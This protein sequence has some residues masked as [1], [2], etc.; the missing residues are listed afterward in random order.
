MFS[1]L[2]IEL[3]I[4]TETSNSSW[5][6]DDRFNLLMGV[7]GGLERLICCQYFWIYCLRPGRLFFC[8]VRVWLDW[9]SWT[10]YRWLLCINSKLRN[11]KNFSLTQSYAPMLLHNLINI[12]EYA[13]D[14]LINVGVFFTL[15]Q[16]IMYFPQLFPFK[17]LIFLHLRLRQSYIK[18]L[19]Y[20][21]QN[22]DRHVSI[23]ETLYSLYQAL[24]AVQILLN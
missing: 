23:C 21:I 7:F 24:F 8:C 1:V 16:L 14:D 13:F 4:F 19:S 5:S 20:H 2:R 10:R 17:F 15:Y 6:P 12:W 9:V 3:A 18:R 22:T 11:V